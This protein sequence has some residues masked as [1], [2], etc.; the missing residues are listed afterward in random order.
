[1]ISISPE[2]RDVLRFL[3]V[4]NIS[5]GTDDEDKAF[6]VKILSRCLLVKGGFNL[7]KFVT[8]S[9]TLRDKFDRDMKKVKDA[10]SGPNIKQ[11]DCFY[12]DSTLGVSSTGHQKTRVSPANKMLTIPWLELL[13]SVLLARLD[14]TVQNAL[15]SEL[16]LGNKICYTDSKNR[17]HEV[18]A[19]VHP[20]SEYWYYCPGSNNPADLPS[21]GI[22]PLELSK[23]MLQQFGPDWIH[24]PASSVWVCLFTCCIARTVH[25]KL[26]WDMTAQA[27]NR[28]LK[29]FTSRRGLPFLIV[30]DNRV[31]IEWQ[32]NLE[33]APWWGGM[34]ERLVGSMK[35]LRKTVGQSKLTFDE[36]STAITEVE[37]LLNSRPL[38][39]VST[40][41]LEEHLTPADFLLGRRSLSLP[42]YGEESEDINITSSAFT[43]R[44]TNEYLL[45]LKEAHRYSNGSRNSSI[46]AVGDTVL[47]HDEDK[48]RGFW[49]L[50][51]IMELIVG[52][53]GTIRGAF[54]SD[55]SNVTSD[56]PTGIT[57]PSIDSL[58]EP[59]DPQSN[60]GL[61]ITIS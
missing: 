5:L 53:D 13:S 27:F 26:V 9:P 10:V 48:P 58:Y 34:F 28:A 60:A 4:N 32:F 1:M 46:P 18:R 25:L 16:K 8:N 19:L 39:F 59:N 36:L 41:D 44:W 30:S 3:C 43:K 57:P 22:N 40:E 23:S 17:V 50:S 35:R 2:D 33:K 55:S 45:E 38:S 24:Q 29:R 47:V 20:E 21:R 15:S 54:L 56:V 12:I 51:R 42:D 6:E 11:E 61:S 14:S 7:R 31:S 37:G 49:K 52:S